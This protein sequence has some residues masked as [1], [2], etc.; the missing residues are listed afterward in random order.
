MPFRQQRARAPSRRRWPTAGSTRP[1]WRPGW[2]PTVA[3]LLRFAD[4]FGAVARP[5]GA[6]L[7]RA[8]G[9]GPRGGRRRRWSCSATTVRCCRCRRTSG[10]WPC[11]GGWPRVANL[12]DGG[13][14]DVLPARGVDAARRGPGRVPDG[15]G[16]PPRHRRPDRPRGPTCA[17]WSWDSPR[18]T[19]ASSSTWARASRWRRCSRRRPSRRPARPPDA[20][21]DRRADAAGAG[22]RRTRRGPPRR[23][24]PDAPPGDVRPGRRPADAPAPRRGRGP[25]GRGGGRLP[26]DG[27]GGHGRFGRGHAVAG[28]GAGHA[29]GLVPG[30][31]GRAG[32][33]RRPDRGASSREG[34]SRSP[35]R[36]T[37]PT[38]SPSTRTPTPSSTTSS[39]AS[40]SSTGTASPPHRPFGA[41]LGYTD[42]GAGPG[43]GPAATGTVPTSTAG[44]GRGRRW[45]TP[46]TGP[47][48]RWCSCFAGLPG[49]AVDRPVRRL[50][51]S[52]GSPLD[53]GRP[54]HG[55]AGRSTWPTWPSGA[56]APGSRSRA[57]TCSAWAPTPVDPVGHGRPSTWR[58]SGA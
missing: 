17:W 15:R 43:V 4:V 14:S 20:R 35:C 58:R 1:T 3:T 40:G 45:P 24:G 29:G 16:G 26:P 50:V 57:P 31:G 30:H 34:G 33:G 25:G 32:P 11:S 39:T 55:H 38:S 49:S 22:R 41:G 53:A 18:T 23:R 44:T 48:R 6:G 9:P 5:V 47:G 51:A 42:L 37:R 12:G 27:G 28:R 7:P 36:P 46:A 52:A 19:R 2:R 56:T 21:R 10:G 13:S 8:P 54:H